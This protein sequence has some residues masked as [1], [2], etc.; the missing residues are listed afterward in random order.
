M[1]GIRDTILQHY[2]QEF[3]AGGSLS[4]ADL[5]P[6][7]DSLLTET[8]EKLLVQVLTLWNTKGV[9]E[10]ELFGLA[11]LMRSR[12]TRIQPQ[13]ET[14]VD[15]VGTGGSRAKTFNVSTAAAVVVAGAGVPVAKHGNRAATSNSGSSDALAML[16]VNANVSPEQAERCL[17]E[18][19]I[20]FMF[21]PRFHSLSAPLAAARKKFGRPT[22][23]NA[24]GPLCNPAGATHQIIGVWDH[25]IFDLE[26]AVLARLGTKR[27][28]IV[29]GSNGLDEISPGQTVVAEVDSAVIKRSVLDS[30][31]F[32]SAA[33]NAELPIS[34]SPAESAGLIEAI[35]KN[36]MAD[37][38]AEHLVLVNSAATLYIA[39]HAADLREGL[40]MARESIRCGN[41]L[42]KLNA[43]REATV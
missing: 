37:S 15:I 31:D 26:A 14:V 33:Q 18:I 38:S 22:I 32:G 1:I 21:A 28:W 9:A 30:A 29:H 43:L 34:R 20:C 25:D 10:E 23:F 16:G 5:E 27:S 36:H 17:N 35:L 11:K 13:A 41:A 12:M 3:A 4:A 42:A 8:D 24:L 19:G 2:V 40:E 39:G 6:F 7:F